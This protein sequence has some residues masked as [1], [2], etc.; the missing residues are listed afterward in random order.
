[1]LQLE[2][3]HINLLSKV[4]LKQ[5]TSNKLCF[6]IFFF[7]YLFLIR[8]HIFCIFFLYE[9]GMIDLL[10]F[11]SGVSYYL[12]KINSSPPSLK[13]I[14]FPKMFGKTQ[15]FGS[16]SGS[17]RIRI[18]WSDPDPYQE[19]LIWIRV[20]PKINQNHGTNKSEWFVNALFTWRKFFKI[21]FNNLMFT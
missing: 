8:C 3:P 18:I 19:T 5:Y 1:M 4:S 16:G 15:C 7:Y 10:V 20:A 21:I 12:E 9:N 6:I 17:G 11:T 2:L 14:Y 13:T